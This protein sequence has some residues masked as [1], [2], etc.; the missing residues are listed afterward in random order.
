MFEHYTKE[1][2]ERLSELLVE[3]VDFR[4]LEAFVIELLDELETARDM[5]LE[6]KEERD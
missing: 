6:H 3:P 1:E 4:A 5:A 2:R